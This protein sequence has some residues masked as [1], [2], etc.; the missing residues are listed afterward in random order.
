[1]AVNR[2]IVD[3]PMPI[4]YAVSCHEKILNNFLDYRKCVKYNSDDV[5]RV[6]K[7]PIAN[8]HP[9]TSGLL[10]LVT[11]MHLGY[12]KV[13]VLGISADGSG[14]YYDL[15]SW[16]ENYWPR[17]PAEHEDWIKEFATWTNIEVAS[18]NL[19]KFFPQIKLTNNSRE[20]N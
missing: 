5:I 20:V 14:H 4:K 18:G 11:A 12:D 16:G 10:A 13:R 7:S 15:V 2:A 19:L 17:W 8:L 1:M 9:N 3:L 6:C